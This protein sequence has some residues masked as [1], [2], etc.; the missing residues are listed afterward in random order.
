MVSFVKKTLNQNEAIVHDVSKNK[1][2][3]GIFDKTFFDWR[4]AITE[5]IHKSMR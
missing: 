4:S 1:W 2:I 3:W 5:S